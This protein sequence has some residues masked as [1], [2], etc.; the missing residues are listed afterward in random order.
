[1]H[2]M[3]LDSGAAT[4]TGIEQCDAGTDELIEILVSRDD[5]HLPAPLYTLHRERSDHVVRFIPVER[6]QGNAEGGEQ[7]LDPLYRAVK[8]DLKLGIEL[9]AGGLVFGVQRGA[10]G[11]ACVVDP[12]QV[13][14]LV[15]LPQFQ[16]EI[17]DAQS[18]RGILALR[19][20]Q[21]TRDQGVERSVDEGV[22]VDQVKMGRIVTHGGGNLIASARLA[23]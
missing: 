18:C 20:A 1:V 6:Y 16:Q 10:E 9:L 14:R 3:L 22:A 17:D 12:R 5:D 19:G 7:L 23:A 8:V 21:R 13:I 4:T 15:L 11:I 2:P